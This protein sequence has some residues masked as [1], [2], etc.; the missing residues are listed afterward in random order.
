MCQA[1]STEHTLSPVLVSTNAM[2]RRSLLKMPPPRRIM[3][4]VVLALTLATPVYANPFKK[5]GNS[6]RDVA[7]LGEDG[8]ARDRERARQAL[9]RA[10][11]QAK[12][13]KIFGATLFSH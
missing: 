6:L 10:E 8:R 7:T 2:T 11:E 3:T 1:I 5:L 12:A 13:A 4:A 9:I